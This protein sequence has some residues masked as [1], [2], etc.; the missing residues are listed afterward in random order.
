MGMQP[1]MIGEKLTRRAKVA[2][3]EGPSLVCS[4]NQTGLDLLAED[5]FDKTLHREQ[6]RSERSRKAIVLML[7]EVADFV[8]SGARESVF[9]KLLSAVS[10]STR[11][12]DIVGWFQ[13]RKVIGVIFTEIRIEE[14]RD[15]SR[16]LWQKASA[17]LSA[18]LTEEEAQQIEIAIHVYPDDGD[19]PRKGSFTNP[20]HLTDF[21]P[22]NGANGVSLVAKKFIDLTGSLLALIVLAPLFVGIAI[23]I[24][25]TSEGPVFFRQKRVGL[26]GRPFTFLKFRSMLVS[27]DHAIHEE[28]VKQFIAG[29]ASTEQG[30]NGKGRVY[31]LT[32]DPRITPIGNFLR[33]TSLDELPQFINVLIG[34]MSLVGPR[35]PI[36]YEVNKYDIWHRRRFLSVKP[37]ITGLWQV[38]GRSK[39]TFDEMVRLD[40]RYARSWSLGLDLVIL[41]QTP[42]AVFKGEGAC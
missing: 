26:H 27:C 33:R 24:K 12:T 19:E 7:F 16:V 37:G 11:E 25:L 20:I 21:K 28:Y 14:A 38:T 2:S 41:L 17:S 6:R 34:D 40:L 10:R 39:T 18:T 8:K 32:T 29:S 3:G 22:K 31:K 15:V 9:P 23:A 35:P 13:D 1:M 36:P 5:A 30:S 4:D 42:L